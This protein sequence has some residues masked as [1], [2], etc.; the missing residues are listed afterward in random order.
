MHEFAC[1]NFIQYMDFLGSVAFIGGLGSAL[2][3]CSRIGHRLEPLGMWN[4]DESPGKE[5]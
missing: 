2:V 5:M 1:L 3:T 4:W